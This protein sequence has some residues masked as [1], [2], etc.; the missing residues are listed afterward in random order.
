MLR[1]K[2]CWKGYDGVDAPKWNLQIE[3]FIVWWIVQMEEN[4]HMLGVVE[5][6]MPPW[7]VVGKNCVVDSW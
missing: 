4:M 6:H 3:P 7:R 2:T 1:Q 5:D